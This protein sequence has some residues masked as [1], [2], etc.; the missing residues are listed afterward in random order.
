MFVDEEEGC[1]GKSGCLP[2]FCRSNFSCTCTEDFYGS[3]SH[4]LRRRFIISQHRFVILLS[5]SCSQVEVAALPVKAWVE[6][7]EL[8]LKA[9]SFK[10]IYTA[11]S[12]DLERVV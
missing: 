6:V 10:F 2:H 9:R 5:T 3:A 1:M 12:C 7:S 11:F 8:L 4:G